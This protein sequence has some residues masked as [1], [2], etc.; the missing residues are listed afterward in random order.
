MDDEYQDLQ[1][2]LTGVKHRL[3]HFLEVTPYGEGFD[4]E[5]V[6]IAIEDLDDTLDA[7]RSAILDEDEETASTLLQEAYAHV[8]EALDEL[9][10][11][12]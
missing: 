4:P 5:R 2:Q 7:L 11:S 12:L 10:R 8:E 9:E 1:L 3:K 6:E